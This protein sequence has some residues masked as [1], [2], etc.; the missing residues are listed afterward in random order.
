M[1]KFADRYTAGKTLAKELKDYAQKKEV[2]VL[3]LPR[4]G[5]P[6]AYEIAK[7]LDVP[8]DVFIVRKL[9][10]PM[11]EELAMGAIATGDAVV[12]NDEIIEQLSISKASIDRVI[13]AEKQELKRR[14]VA[15]RGDR[16]YPEFK[17]KKV[18]LVDDGIATGA[19]MRAAI[20]AIRQQSPSEIIV[21]VPVAAFTTCVELSE[22]VDK[23]VCPLKPT[24]FYAVGAWYDDFTQT[25]DEE[26]HGLLAKLEKQNSHS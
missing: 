15:Y 7:S 12:F 20:K 19:S 5:V 18:I 22:L 17:N 10:V 6:V 24:F 1:D 11:Q 26:V 16:P 4:G 21:A 8:M 3:A 13:K 23:V 14:E 2:I 25:T 9:G